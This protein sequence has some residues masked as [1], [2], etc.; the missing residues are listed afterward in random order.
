MP[1]LEMSRVVLAYGV[2]RSVDGLHNFEYEFII[3]DEYL[4]Y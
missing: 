4:M 3:V 1:R 2:G